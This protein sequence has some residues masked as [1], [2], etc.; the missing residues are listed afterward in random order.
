MADVIAF[1]R[2]VFTRNDRWAPAMCQLLYVVET[3]IKRGEWQVD[4]ACDPS[5]ALCHV[6]RLLL[7]KGYPI[8]DV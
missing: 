1:D 8:E 4:G 3:A 6:K 7:A 5:L 2:T